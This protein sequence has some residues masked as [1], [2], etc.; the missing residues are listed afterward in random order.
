[1]SLPASPL[2]LG[3]GTTSSAVL[4]RKKRKTFSQ[5]YF[6]NFLRVVFAML[7]LG[8]VYIVSAAYGFELYVMLGLVA[9]AG[10]ALILSI[11]EFFRK[12]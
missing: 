11:I 5:L 9:A 10:I 6:D 4:P 2:D 12:K 1:M 8:V 3:E 7:V